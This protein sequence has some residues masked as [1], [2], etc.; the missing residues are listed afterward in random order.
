[1][2]KKADAIVAVEPV[3]ASL[4]R[5]DPNN[6]VSIYMDPK[7]YDQVGRVADMMASSSLIPDA[8]RN[9]PSDCFLIAAQ[10]FRWRMDPFA[11]AQSCYAARGK[12]GYEGK[13]IA[14]LIN[15]RLEKKLDYEY[16]GKEGSDSRKVTVT[17]TLR[18]ES[19]QRSISGTFS[20]W[21]TKNKTNTD[22]SSQWKKG[23]DQML[24]YRG[25][26]EWARR[27]MPE[28]VLGIYSIDEVEELE[29]KESTEKTVVESNDIVEGFLGGDL[30]ATD[31]PSEE[32]RSSQSRE[33]VVEDVEPEVEPKPEPA[34]KAKAKKKTYK[35]GD[36]LPDGRLVEEVDADGIPTVVSAGKAKKPADPAKKAEPVKSNPKPGPETDKGYTEEDVDALFGD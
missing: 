13:I 10:A 24:A 23:R 9:K 1:M 11:V 3:E 31:D 28:A 25:A 27:H 4:D 29:A 2:T 22:W 34:K 16:E 33:A 5:Y 30:S 17:G 20:E 7:R 21:A 36:F 26:R 35:P 18:G 6:P 32:N 12:V 8:L 15:A 19:R 14:A